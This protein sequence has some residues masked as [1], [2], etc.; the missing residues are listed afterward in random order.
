MAFIH[1]LHRTV[2]PK[3]CA[4]FVGSRQKFPGQEVRISASLCQK[5]TVTLRDQKRYLRLRKL[6]FQDFSATQL[7]IRSPALNII[8]DSISGA[9]KIQFRG[10]STVRL[11]QK[12]NISSATNYLI[13]GPHHLLIRPRP[14]WKPIFGAPKKVQTDLSRNAIRNVAF[15]WT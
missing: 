4:W 1:L 12:K 6:V 2:D 15:Q 11:D 5:P 9:K 3:W 10:I 14:H 8:F 13:I 7:Q